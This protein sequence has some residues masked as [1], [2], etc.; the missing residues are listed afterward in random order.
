MT[1]SAA[2]LDRSRNP[3]LDKGCCHRLHPPFRTTATMQGS[4]ELPIDGVDYSSARNFVTT[5]EQDG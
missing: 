4:A 1:M 3:F 2:V 5:V